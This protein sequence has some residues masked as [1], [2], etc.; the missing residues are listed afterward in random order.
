MTAGA[1]VENAA[2]LVDL[3]PV[4]NTMASSAQLATRISCCFKIMSVTVA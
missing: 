2:E 4:N 1:G 3:Q